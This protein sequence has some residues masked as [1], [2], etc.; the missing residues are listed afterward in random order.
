MEKHEN[1]KSS[2]I[3]MKLSQKDEKVVLSIIDLKEEI[4]KK[5]EK[6]EKKINKTQI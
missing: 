5:M 3:S 1:L 6:I 2:L 4:K